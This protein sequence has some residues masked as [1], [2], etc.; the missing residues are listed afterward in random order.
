MCFTIKSMQL[1]IY[2]DLLMLSYTLIEKLRNMNVAIEDAEEAIIPQM[3]MNPNVLC[4]MIR[5][6]YYK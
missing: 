2:C 5:H 4:Y 3:P 1:I 6:Q